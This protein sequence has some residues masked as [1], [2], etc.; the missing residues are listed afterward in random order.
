M[1]AVT[2]WFPYYVLPKR[3]G[4][5]QRKYGVQAVTDVLDYWDGRKWIVCGP[6]GL[7]I[8]NAHESRP[9]RGLA[10]EP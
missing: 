10:V 5:Y 7:Q 9:W 1:S 3:K 6:D 2:Q 4:F 8:G